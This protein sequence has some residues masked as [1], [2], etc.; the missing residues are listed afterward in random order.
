M[1]IVRSFVASIRLKIIFSFTGGVHDLSIS[2]DCE[3]VYFIDI[4]DFNSVL[5]VETGSRSLINT[6]FSCVFQD[7]VYI[8]GN[9]YAYC[10]CMVGLEVMR[11]SRMLALVT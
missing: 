1:I 10:H 11:Q 5:V 8:I 2:T 4:V 9:A 6:D 7:S 3:E